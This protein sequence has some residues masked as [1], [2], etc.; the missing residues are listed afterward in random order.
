MG[1]PHVAETLTLSIYP[2]V[3]GSPAHSK[4]QRDAQGILPKA[5][6]QGTRTRV[7][8]IPRM[9]TREAKGEERAA[10]VGPAQVLRCTSYLLIRKFLPKPRI[11]EQG[12]MRGP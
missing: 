7:I 11:C 1:Q 10:W 8:P 4:Q 6:S 9:L 3:S 12:M 5:K 2:A